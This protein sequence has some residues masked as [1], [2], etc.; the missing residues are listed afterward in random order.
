MISNS[1]TI[2]A[3]ATA[4][5]IGSVSITRISGA[6]ALKIAQN[7]TQTPL[8]PR[9]AHYCKI[10]ID[11][12]FIDEAIVIYFKAPFSFTG[13]DVV[14][15]QTHGGFVISNLIM[16]EAVRLGARFA[17]PG[18][19]SK[20]AFLN[21]KMDLAKANAISNLILSR[22]EDSVRILARSLNGELSE[23]ANSLR[24]ELVKTL[25]YCETTIDYAEDDLPADILSQIRNLLSENAQKLDKI[26]QISQSRR[27]LIDGFKIA[28]IGKP[29]VGKSSILNALLNSNRAI[30]SD[31][32]GTTRDTIEEN[33]RVGTHLVRIIDTAGIRDGKSNIEKIGI[34]NSLKAANLADIIIAV[35]DGSQISDAD[36]KRILEICDKFGSNV[37]FV[38]NKNDLEFKFDAPLKNAIKISAKN[39]VSAIF[40]AL[41]EILNSKNYDGLMLS[42]QHEIIACE[43]VK[44]ALLRANEL[45]DERTLELFAFEI[46]RAISEISSI[47]RPFERSEILDEMFS[48]FCLGK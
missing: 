24:S 41:E 26:V 35:F 29:N 27:G 11:G 43:N 37:I 25:A 10:K 3:E 18:E 1:D 17:Q 9:C 46:N 40:S 8:K 6:N 19:F 7:F 30:T 31:E 32:A 2:V 36:D 47:T 22:S 39:D 14:E 33:L 5:G 44:E 16:N 45:L 34:E 42:S 20:R 4:H 48:N 15:I 23:Y 38:L 13:E 28:I 21:G 12:E